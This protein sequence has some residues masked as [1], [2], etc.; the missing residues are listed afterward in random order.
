MNHRLTGIRLF[1]RTI[2]YFLVFYFPF[3]CMVPSLIA[4]VSIKMCENNEQYSWNGKNKKNKNI[5]FQGTEF[6]VSHE[7]RFFCISLILFFIFFSFSFRFFFF[8][9]TLVKCE[10]LRYQRKVKAKKR[11]KEIYSR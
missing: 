11:K 5:K 10:I 9:L 7:T 1:I 3:N 2:L 8:R 4:H 6:G